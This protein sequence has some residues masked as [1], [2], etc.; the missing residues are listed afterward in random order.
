MVEDRQTAVATPVARSARGFVV[1]LSLVVFALASCAVPPPPDASHRIGPGVVRA[2]VPDAGDVSYGDDPAQRLDIYLPVG[3]GSRGVIVLVHGGAFVQGSREEVA[4]LS[5]VIMTQTTRGFAVVNVGYRLRTGTTNL[6]PAAVDDI[7]AAITWIRQH[8]SE[9]GIDTRLLIVAGHSAGGTI[10]SL[11]ATGWNSPA[12]GPLGRT[13]KVDGYISFAG[14]MDFNTKV[15]ATRNLG[16]D[17]VGGGIGAAG[18][19]A[20]ASPASHLDRQDPPGYLAHGVDD[21]VVEPGQVDS[22][23]S[24]LIKSGA[25]FT[26]LFVDRTS[27][28]EVIC[29]WHVPQCG[30][31]AT[32]LNKWIDRVEEHRL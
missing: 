2:A 27:S 20:A 12:S 21:N 3:G 16:L 13:P 11:I 10:A 9:Y 25:P 31:N 15:P 8:G 5:G 32:E 6:F 23:V 19:L 29:R 28:G 22:M 14:I 4:R 1:V 18:R 26:R 30:V 7:G 17:W 24:A